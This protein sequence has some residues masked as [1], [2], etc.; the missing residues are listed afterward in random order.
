MILEHMMER[1]LSLTHHAP[2]LVDLFKGSRKSDH[3]SGYE[4]EKGSSYMVKEEKARLSY[5][6][7]SQLTS[8]K[9]GLVIT[10]IYPP[11]LETQF[12]ISGKIFWLSAIDRNNTLPPSDLNK[13][14]FVITSFI[15]DHD[16]CVILL[17]GIEYL[18]LQNGFKKVFD[19]ISFITE[20]I[21]QNKAI[22]LIPA[23]PK[24][25]TQKEVMLLERKLEPC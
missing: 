14:S 24:A 18:I 12:D 23:S 13:L 6:V 15:E 2:S 9:D 3:S 1:V 10:R 22:L 17:D 21:S 20:K 8:Q 25:L 16:N 19:F 7:F 11:R 4:F 5:Q